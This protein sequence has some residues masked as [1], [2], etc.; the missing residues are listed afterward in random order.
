M[1]LKNKTAIEI[2]D[3]IK[4]KKASCR[5][6]VSY[7]LSNI[8]K[9]K[10][11][12]AILEV[13]AN[14]ALSKAEEIDKKIKAGEKLPQLAGLPIIIKANLLYEGHIASC[15]SKFLEKYKSQYTS[16]AVQKLLEAGVIILGTANMDEF[17]MG[18]STEN[19]AFG[20]CLNGLDDSRVPGGSS[21]GSAV[22][23]ACNMCPVA[24]GSDTG[25]SIR[26][27]S[28]FNGLVGIKPTYG[29]V[30]RFGLVAFAS[31]TDQISPISKTIEDNALIL[32]VIAGGDCNDET[33]LDKPVPS[34]I[35][36]IKPSIKGMKIA[37]LKETVRLMEKTPYQGVYQNISDWFKKQGAEIIEI[38]IP[39]YSLGL[40]VYYVL[41]SAEATSNL[42]RFDGVKY[43]K[44]SDRAKS[45]GD[46]YKMSR[47]DF[48]GK[49]VKRRIMLGNFVLSSGYFD[50][51]YMKAK[52]IQ[53][54]LKTKLQNAFKKCDCIM[55][56]TT[57]GEAFKIGEKSK[58]VV[59]LYIEDMFTIVP[60]ITGL[61]ALTVPCGKGVSGLPLG[62][63]LIGNELEESTI[64][65]IGKYFMKNKEASHE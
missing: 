49:E 42:G 37:L 12:N 34:Y 58:D 13:F 21:G 20:P 36:E 52:K 22:A 40:P 39:E 4:T 10:H 7:Y 41:S 27:P 46:V 6:V 5:E 47:T 25:G 8:E 60:S 38:S 61:P 32:S 48:F 53:S 3:I 63:Q 29:R 30:S 59:S 28:S 45:I 56:P 24:L 55:M 26:Q 11:K 33:S 57:F 17:A 62:L 14:E 1:E 35:K 64:Y 31:S 19:S 2:L 9:Y 18:G 23:V 15:A 65:T 43:T 44:R 51:Y 50:A 16:T 54:L